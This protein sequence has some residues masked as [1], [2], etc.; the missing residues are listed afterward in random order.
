[1]KKAVKT[2]GNE[3][4]NSV[5]DVLKEVRS[6]LDPLPEDIQGRL[7]R[8]VLY[9][10]YAHEIGH[11]AVALG[12]DC[13]I[14]AFK[15]RFGNGFFYGIPTQTLFFILHFREI[16]EASIKPFL[17]LGGVGFDFVD[18]VDKALV[19]LGDEGGL[20][21]G[22]KGVAKF[23]DLGVKGV[24]AGKNCGKVSHGRAPGKSRG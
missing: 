8:L 12:A 17:K 14:A 4:F 9:R 20:G 23:V 1:M 15:F 3:V 18:A 11:F 22:E 16:F 6:L 2:N 7:D 21:V 24:K 13:E 5:T 10:K 19:V